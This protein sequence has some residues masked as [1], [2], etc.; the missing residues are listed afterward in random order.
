MKLVTP[1]CD[2][3]D[4]IRVST[5]LLVRIWVGHHRYVKAGV[6]L[7]GFSIAASHS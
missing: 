3:R 6:M 5:K 7:A 4:I 2:T 1:S